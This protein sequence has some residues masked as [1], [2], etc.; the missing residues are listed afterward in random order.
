MAAFNLTNTSPLLG[1]PAFRERYTLVAGGLINTA[2]V[3]GPAKLPF[4]L[5]AAG[6]TNGVPTIPAARLNPRYWTKPVSLQSQ[7]NGPTDL[8]GQLNGARNLEGGWT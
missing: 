2:P 7:L 3:L 4:R 1:N 8:E 6:L 5:T